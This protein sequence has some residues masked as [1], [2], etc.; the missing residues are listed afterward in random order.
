M[1]LTTEDKQHLIEWGYSERD[2]PRIEEAMRRDKTAYK[3]GSCSISR[4]DA[5]AALGR[6]EYLSGIA[7]SAFYLSS[8]RTGIDGRVVIFD[9][10]RLFGKR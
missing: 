8:A 2:L 4:E 1:K 5:I 7:R 10:S 6:L 9:S 3:I